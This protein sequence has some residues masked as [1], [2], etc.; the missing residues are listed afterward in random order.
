MITDAEEKG[1]ISPNKVRLPFCI[2][3]EYYHHEGGNLWRC[4]ILLQT[5]L[6]EPTTGNTGI[7]LA[8]VAAARGYKF[9]ATMPSSVDVER[10]ILIRAFGAE[11]VLTDPKKGLK[12]AFDKAEEIVSKR[13]NAYMFHQFNNSANSE[14]DTSSHCH[15][16]I[17][18]L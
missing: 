5:I 7:G 9:I 15:L 11:I 18:H 4:F 16:L 17:W 8:S 2:C 6:V 1:L 12:G 14:V 10:R 3:L 13:P